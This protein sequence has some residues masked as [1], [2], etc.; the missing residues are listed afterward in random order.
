MKFANAI[1]LEAE[2]DVSRE[3]A[4]I[5]ASPFYAA[6]FQVV[7]DNVDAAGTVKIQ[8]SNDPVLPVNTI[9]GWNDIP[10][11]TVNVTAGGTLLIPKFDSCY[12]Y[13]KVVYTSTTP[14]T[15]TITVRM[16]AFG[17]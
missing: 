3:S 10:N 8:A 6:S 4:P 5:D 11:A 1:V 12:K 14:G 16:M 7:F 13:F 9:T 2:D 17:V 15:G